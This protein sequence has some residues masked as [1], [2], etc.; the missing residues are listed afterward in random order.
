MKRQDSVNLNKARPGGC[1]CAS[2]SSTATSNQDAS[3]IVSNE[4][5]VQRLQVEGATCGGCV[6]SIEQTLRS[7]AGVTEARMEL[8]SGIASVIGAVQSNDLIEALRRVGFPATRV[9]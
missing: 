5:P 6:R 3:G 8:A 7:V 9:N 1:C 4:L 2:Q